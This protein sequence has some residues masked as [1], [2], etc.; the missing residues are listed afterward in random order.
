MSW[1]KDIPGRSHGDL[2]EEGEGGQLP[3]FLAQLEGK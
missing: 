3:G 1:G 2:K